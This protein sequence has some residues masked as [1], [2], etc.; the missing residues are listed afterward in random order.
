MGKTFSWVLM[1]VAFLLLEDAGWS[2]CAMCRTA[3]ESSTEGA[4]VAEGFRRGVLL[5]MAAPYTLLGTISYLVFR[6]YRNQR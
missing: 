6:A 5:L 2:Q 1:L 4:A 3:L